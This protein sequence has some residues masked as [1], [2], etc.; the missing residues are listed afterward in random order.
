MCL[1]SWYPL[2][3]RLQLQTCL[4]PAYPTSSHLSIICNRRRVSSQI[5]HTPMLNI[6]FSSPVFRFTQRIFS[7]TSYNLVGTNTSLMTLSKN[8]KP[9]QNTTSKTIFHQ[10]S[11]RTPKNMLRGMPSK[12]LKT[13]SLQWDSGALLMHHSVPESDRPML[14]LFKFLLA[15]PFSTN[16]PIFYHL[17]TSEN[18]FRYPL[19]TSE[20]LWFSDVFRGNRKKFS[21]V[22]SGYRSG[23][24]VEMD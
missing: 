20:N 18:L 4:P 7:L 8:L 21:Y 9:Y 13:G 15:T 2:G 17:K 11:D 1:C 10:H 23:A 5:Y 14:V 12:K 24:L 19:K 22:F 3:T 6:P 16:V